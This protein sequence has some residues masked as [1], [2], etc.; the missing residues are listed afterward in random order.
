MIDAGLPINGFGICFNK[1]LR[2]GIQPWRPNGLISNFKFYLA[3]ENAI[4]CNDY[5]SEKFWRNAL[6]SGAVPVVYGAHPDDVKAVAPPN[7]YIHVEDFET[8][9]AL[10]EYLDYLDGNDTAYLEYHQWRGIEPDVNS[11]GAL[12]KTAQMTCD[13]CKGTCSSYNN[14]MR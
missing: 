9:A 7:S 4:H 2:H 1:P 14:N 3:F 12:M 13:L 5:L 6:G 8:P 10:V 11:I